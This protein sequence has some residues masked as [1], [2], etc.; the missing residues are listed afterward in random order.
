M[1]YRRVIKDDLKAFGI[2]KDS[3]VEL[4]K[5]RKGWRRVLYKGKEENIRTW[6]RERESR[7]EGRDT[8]RRL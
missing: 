1:N 7:G 5:D 2:D 3:W 6:Y 8:L 4:A